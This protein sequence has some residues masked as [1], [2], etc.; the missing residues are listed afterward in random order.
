MGVI[1]YLVL[2]A[3]GLGTAFLINKALKA[4]KLI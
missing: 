2:V 3:A 4:I 1:F